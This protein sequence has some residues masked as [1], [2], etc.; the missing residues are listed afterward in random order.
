VLAGAVAPVGAFDCRFG[1]TAWFGS[2]VLW[3]A[4]RPDEPFR[5]LTRAVYA[6][7]PG[8]PPYGGGLADVVPHLTIGDRPPGGAAD[9]L[10]AE[11]SLRPGLPVLARISRVRLMTGSDAPDSWRTEAELPLAAG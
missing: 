1:V 4:P 3:L 10:A 7:F 6:A 9:L 11:A 2:E 5:A 8:Y